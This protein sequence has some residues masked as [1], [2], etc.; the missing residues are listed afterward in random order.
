M[1]QPL[2]IKNQALTFTWQLISQA[3][4]KLFKANP[5]LATGDFKI[6]KDGGAFANLTNL[7][8]VTPAGGSTIEFVLT[9][10]EMNADRV[11][12]ECKDAAGAEWCD[13]SINILTLAAATV[14]A[15]VTQVE[16]TDA[17]DF[18]ATLDDAVLSAIAA[19]NNLSQ[20][21]IRTAVGLASA[22]LDTQLADLPTNAELSTALASADDAVLAAVA[23]L[24]N[25]SQADIRT[26]VGLATGN[27]DTQLGDL[28]TNAE[29]ASS[30]AAAD[31]AV[32]AA[33]AALN[34]LSQANIR[35]A[36]GLAS[37]NLDTQLADLPTNAELA[38]SLASADD[39]VLA[40]IAALNNL[41]SAG[42]QSAAAAALA[43]YDAATGADVSA[44][45]AYVDTEVAAIKTIVDKIDTAM[46][47]DGAVYRFTTNALEQAPAGGGGGGG[48]ATLANQ[49]AIL[50]QLDLIQARTD[51]ISVDSE[52]NITPAVVGTTMSIVRGCTLTANFSGLGALT[53]RTAL[54]ITVKHDLEDGDEDAVFKIEES[55][56]LQVLN[57]SYYAS[58]GGSITVTNANTG[59]LTVTLTAAAA[60]LLNA[61]GRKKLYYDMKM[62]N[63]A[64]VTQLING[65]ATITGDV[66]RLN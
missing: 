9:A 33:I 12:I 52:I 4:T 8:T 48:D 44:V 1:D 24:N 65:Y 21:N 57:G 66:T 23:A 38:S 18:F 29:L 13:S 28:P 17:T 35:T 11:A 58:S 54:Y 22:N 7:P 59:A 40:A 60:K 27:L 51:M 46:E 61:S 47:L 55:A 39:A 14:A 37:A 31:D 41:S 43:A 10:S 36:I 15:N 32:L 2:P 42:A 62:V 64:V 50:D 5:T 34:N 25:L 49:T 20:A 53:G 56:G 6:S 45:G 26:A 30:L 3:D 16:G 19:L 63:G